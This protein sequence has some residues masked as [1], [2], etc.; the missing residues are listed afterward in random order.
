MDLA[1]TERG[2]RENGRVLLVGNPWKHGCGSWATLPLPL[3]L[4]QENTLTPLLSHT[5]FIPGHSLPEHAPQSLSQPRKYASSIGIN[6]QSRLT[7]LS[8]RKITPSGQ[9]LLTPHFPSACWWVSY[10]ELVGKSPC[11]DGL[12]GCSTVS[13]RGPQQD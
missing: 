9:V 6:I 2:S 7:I 4:P 10:R 12:E 1:S 13:F 5:W 3:F 8:P 11:W